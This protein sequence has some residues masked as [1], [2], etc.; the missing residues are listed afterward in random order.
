MRLKKNINYLLSIL[1]ALLFIGAC[2]SMKTARKDVATLSRNPASVSCIGPESAT[3][4]AIYLQGQ[5]S[6]PPSQQ[7]LGNRQNLSNLAKALNVRIALPR[8]TQ[9]CPNKPDLLCWGWEFNKQTALDSI[10]TINAAAAACFPN[11]DRM[12][13]IGF[14][15][16]GYLSNQIFQNCLGF[17]TVP[18]TKWFVNAGSTFGSWSS[19]DGSNNYSRC[20]PLVLIAGRQDQ[21]NFDP[22]NAYFDFLKSHGADV[23]LQLF[24]G[25]HILP[26]EPL[27]TAVNWALKEVN[28]GVDQQP[29]LK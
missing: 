13:I 23:A 4:F 26:D 17:Q 10:S 20:G 8:A 2:A 22:K 12:G 27:I 3:Q 19:S 14:S 24:D 6:D 11:A 28:A 25:G 16:G 9:H 21:F 1:A 29:Q 15:S 7:E 5:D 18:I